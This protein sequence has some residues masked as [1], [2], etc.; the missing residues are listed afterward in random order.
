MTRGALVAVAVMSLARSAQANITL[1]DRES[2]TLS[3]GGRT[4]G[5]YSFASGDAFPRGEPAFFIGEGPVGAVGGMDN[6]FTTSRLRGGWAAN[7]FGLTVTNQINDCLKATGRVS[8]WF[9]V[10]GDQTKGNN[11]DNGSLDIRQGFVKL[12]GCWGG[13]LLGRNLG[14][15]SRGSLLQDAFISADE[16]SVGSP[17]SITGLGITCGQVGYGVLMPGFNAGIVYNTPEWHG[18]TLSVGGYDPRRIGP[19]TGGPSSYGQT[20][21][22]RLEAEAVEHWERSSLTVD[23]FTNGMWQKAGQTGG[24]ATIEAYGFGY[25][26]RIGLGPAKLGFVGGWD[27]GG[28]MY[29]PL[30]DVAIDAEGHLRN[31]ATYWGQAMYSIGP[32]DLTGGVGTAR[33][34]ATAADNADPMVSLIKR[35]LGINGAVLWHLGPVVLVAQ[36]FRMVHTW[37]RGQEQAINVFNTGATFNW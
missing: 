19:D 28:G 2:W 7:M 11:N 9:T 3:I 33:M 14:L 24:E 10:E 23:L 15:H 27:H 16:Y 13:V 6:K 31:V 25:G 32:V 12:E 4:Q 34:Y 18:F 8:F 21:L 1:Y 26:G 20:P 35:H 36:Y 22:P 37:H 17:C 29:V 5:F 30:G